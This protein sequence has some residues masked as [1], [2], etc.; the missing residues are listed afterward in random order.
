[1]DRS[2]THCMSSFWL[3]GLTEFGKSA[4]VFLTPLIVLHLRHLLIY[5]CPSVKEK[6][7]ASF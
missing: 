7:S 2:A 3:A 4:E 1:V 5:E 6:P